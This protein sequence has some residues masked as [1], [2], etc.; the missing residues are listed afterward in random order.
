MQKQ[1]MSILR[2]RFGYSTDIHTTCIYTILIFLF[3]LFFSVS[4][5]INSSFIC[6][7]GASFYFEF[8]FFFPPLGSEAADGVVASP[9]S[10]QNLLRVGI[11]SFVLQSSYLSLGMFISLSRRHS[12]GS[13]RS[14]IQC[15]RAG[16]SLMMVAGIPVEHQTVVT[17]VIVW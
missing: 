14:S 2:V 8:L 16:S 4:V 3:S 12:T 9:P 15:Q 11:V 5:Q 13:G 7:R 1:A 6:V 10:L 17:S